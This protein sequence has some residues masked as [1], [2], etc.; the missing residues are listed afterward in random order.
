MT[1]KEVQVTVGGMP[2]TVQVNDADPAALRFDIDETK[3]ART[4]A[5][6]KPAAVRKARTP[7]NKAA[8]PAAN[9]ATQPVADKAASSVEAASDPGASE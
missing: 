9:K 1:I 5:P 7:R 4:A 2:H 6:K 8:K 3:A